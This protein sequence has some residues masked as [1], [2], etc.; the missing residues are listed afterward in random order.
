MKVLGTIVSGF[1]RVF[2]GENILFKHISI[3]SLAGIFGMLRFHFDG[4][5]PTENISQYLIFLL[6][7]VAIGLYF[8]GYMLSFC[9][10]CFDEDSQNILPE[11]DEKPVGI[12]LSV[13]TL[14]I[15]WFLYILLFSILGIIPILGWIF[16]LVCCFTWFPFLGFI[17]IAYS[18]NFSKEG[19]YNI[20]LPFTYAKHSF[21]TYVAFA[22]TLMVIGIIVYLPL[23]IA[24]VCSAVMNDMNI[25]TYFGVSVITVI[26]CYLAT[27]YTFVWQYCLVQIYKEKILPNLE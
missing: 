1:K 13:I 15:A 21:G 10:N 3:F 11:F 26:G 4:A 17:N 7:Y 9:H 12:L 23:I 20:K 25:G 18:K 27:I 19:L 22:L 16:M 24:T 8:S 6:L 5:N 14:V 2:L